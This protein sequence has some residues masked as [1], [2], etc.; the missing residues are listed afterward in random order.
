M[1]TDSSQE[2]GPGSFQN[3][4]GTIPGKQ[5]GAIAAERPRTWKQQD[6]P[7]RKCTRSPKE[8]QRLSSPC[9]S[10][11]SHTASQGYRNL[12]KMSKKGVAFQKTEPPTEHSV[13]GG[14]P[15]RLLSVVHCGPLSLA[16][17]LCTNTTGASAAHTPC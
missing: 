15:I 3:L 6:A 5:H 7:F 2:A 9:L 11:S 13:R 1:H 16:R 10:L 8:T 14:S 4:R 17:A 12:T